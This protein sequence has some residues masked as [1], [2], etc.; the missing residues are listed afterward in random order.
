MI[1]KASA[2]SNIALIKYMG[3]TAD[4][5][6]TGVNPS[7]SL[8]LNHLLSHVA[9]QENSLGHDEW[10]SMDGKME[11]SATGKAKFLK[12]FQFLKEVFVISDRFFTVQSK[13]DFPSDCGI[14]SS[15]SSFAALTMA[16]CS[17][18]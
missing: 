17:A 14:A 2:P 13:N 16:S 3:K 8:T 18:F 6:N 10:R 7:L 15:A 9:I 1:W 4:G 5:K 12:H 11:L